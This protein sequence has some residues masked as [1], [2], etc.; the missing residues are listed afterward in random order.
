MSSPIPEKF[1]ILRGTG[2]PGE[3]IRAVNEQGV[4][5]FRLQKD[6]VPDG[7]LS[8]AHSEWLDFSGK[9][10]M[11][12]TGSEN[13]MATLGECQEAQEFS[14]PVTIDDKKLDKKLTRRETSI[15]PVF[16]TRVCEDGSF[17]LPVPF[18]EMQEST[19]SLWYQGKEWK[20]K[21]TNTMENKITLGE[22]EGGC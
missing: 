12:K 17:Y 2:K 21:I 16:E 15:I 14:Y 10:V 1:T 4:Q 6:Y 3:I 7:L 20:T 22:L 9:K 8:I 5:Q 18:G 19:I 13:I 11:I